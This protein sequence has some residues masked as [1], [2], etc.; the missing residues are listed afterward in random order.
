MVIRNK[1]LGAMRIRNKQIRD[2]GIGNKRTGNAGMGIE[3]DQE[4]ENREHICSD[5]P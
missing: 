1:L 3:G 2:N 4:H 5:C